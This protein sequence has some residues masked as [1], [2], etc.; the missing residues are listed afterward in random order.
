MTMPDQLA[1]GDET[2]VQV[3]ELTVDAAQAAVD[4]VLHEIAAGE[5]RLGSLRTRLG[6]E[7]IEG[8]N[9]AAT[10]TEIREVEDALADL[11]MRE[12]HNRAELASAEARARLAA[13]HA[14]VEALYRHDLE[15]LRA[16]REVMGLTLE[17]H[18][19]RA[20]LECTD[21]QG[22]D[23]RTRR[24]RMRRQVVAALLGR[25]PDRFEDVLLSKADSPIRVES[26]AGPANDGGPTMA[27]VIADIARFEGLLRDAEAA[28]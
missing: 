25:E 22:R 24:Y 11:R 14:A 16:R 28:R 9:T 18:H 5:E 15:F 13:A 2:M 26:V 23:Y 1:E 19:A 3:D 7:A 20:K 12:S 17:L 27:E 8:G 10:R 21:E 4:G 6:R